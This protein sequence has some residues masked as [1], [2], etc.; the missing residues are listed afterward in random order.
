M[1]VMLMLMA[2]MTIECYCGH[3][4]NHQWYHTHKR[5]AQN[6]MIS[7][8]WPWTNNTNSNGETDGNDSESHQDE[9]EANRAILP[10]FMVDLSL[11]D[12]I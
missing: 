5:H 6:G 3:S 2:M 1:F 4:L 10:G 7:G 9:I 12:P 8:P 11:I